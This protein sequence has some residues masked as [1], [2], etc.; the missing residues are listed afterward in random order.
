MIQMLENRDQQN[1]K[2]HRQC[3]ERAMGR[4]EINKRAIP[5]VTSGEFLAKQATTN[6]IIYEK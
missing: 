5:K 2:A 1:W 6:I 4:F 3:L